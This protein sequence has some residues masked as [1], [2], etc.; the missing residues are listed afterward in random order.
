MNIEGGPPASDEVE[1]IAKKIAEWRPTLPPDKV[2]AQIMGRAEA[3]R[4]DPKTLAE[5]YLVRARGGIRLPWE[6]D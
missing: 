3:A 2:V 5:S 4:C 6:S 1:R